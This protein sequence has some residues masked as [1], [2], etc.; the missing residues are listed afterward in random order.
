MG[1]R[2]AVPIVAKN[3][4]PLDNHTSNTEDFTEQ[5]ESQDYD[6]SEDSDDSL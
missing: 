6:D 3:L 2:N 5:M 4:V 1:C